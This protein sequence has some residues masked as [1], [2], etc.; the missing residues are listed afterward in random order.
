MSHTSKIQVIALN[1]TLIVMF[2]SLGL[3]H[4]ASTPTPSAKIG[5]INIQEAI[6]EC[7]EGKKELDALQAK[8]TPK[9]DELGKLNDEVVNLKKQYD[10]QKDK[11]TSEASAGQLKA[12]KA[13]QNTLQ[14]TLANAQNEVQRAE[15]EVINRIGNKMMKV[16]DKYAKDHGYS[17][18]LDVA[19]PQTPVIWA[20]QGMNITKE[21][22]QAYNAENPTA[23]QA[24]SKNLSVPSNP[25]PFTLYPKTQGSKPKKP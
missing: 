22:I 2:S 4:P 17:L 6:M 1:L 3:A 13:K 19:N 18:I 24:P 23:A 7:N 16:L 11:L 20:D 21:L 15:Q 10:A 14:R 5:I 12:L 9:Q 8:F 25:P